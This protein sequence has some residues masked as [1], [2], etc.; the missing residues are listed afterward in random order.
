VAVGGGW[1][2]QAAQ[3]APQPRAAA[4]R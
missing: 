1:V 4:G 3:Q 2:D